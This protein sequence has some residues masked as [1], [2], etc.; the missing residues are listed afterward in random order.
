MRDRHLPNHKLT[1][2]RPR[3][4]SSV[5]DSHTCRGGR[6]VAPPAARALARHG[7]PRRRRR[8]PRA[9]RLVLLPQTLDGAWPLI[10]SVRVQSLTPQKRSPSVT[11]AALGTAS[12]ALHLSRSPPPAGVFPE[13]HFGGV[14]QQL[15]AQERNRIYPLALSPAPT[16]AYSVLVELGARTDGS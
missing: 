16:D 13:G 15:G 3:A 5:H 6:A 1:C 7:G 11:V 4:A 8:R 9:A 2:L 10:A 12:A 14:V